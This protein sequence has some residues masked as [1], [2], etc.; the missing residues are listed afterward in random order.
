MK[1]SLHR[2]APHEKS[3]SKSAENNVRSPGVISIISWL[4][5]EENEIEKK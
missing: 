2:K 5:G 1:K 3:A 4:F